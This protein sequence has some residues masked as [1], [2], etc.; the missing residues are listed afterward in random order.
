MIHSAYDPLWELMTIRIKC[1]SITL[2]DTFSADKM[3]AEMMER[4]KR[5]GRVSFREWLARLLI[6]ISWVAQGI[7]DK[8]VVSSQRE[9]R[10]VDN[11]KDEQLT[12]FIERLDSV[13]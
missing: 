13:N 11:G 8:R 5:D 6:L 3:S 10:S 1:D 9:K 4:G 12:E 2:L 7:H